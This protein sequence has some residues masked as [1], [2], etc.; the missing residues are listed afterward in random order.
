MSAIPAYPCPRCHLRYATRPDLDAHFD[1]HPECRAY[2][3]IA[4]SLAAVGAIICPRCLL[5]IC[6]TSLGVW[7]SA[8]GF[9]HQGCATADERAATGCQTLQEIHNA[10][11]EATK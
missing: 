2:A 3:S 1:T 6:M 9:V 5:A 7:T 8:D 4:R 11:K 10:S